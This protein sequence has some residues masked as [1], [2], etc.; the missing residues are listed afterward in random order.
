MKNI[1]FDERIGASKTINKAKVIRRVILF[2]IGF[3]TSIFFL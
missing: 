1:S 3:S 2:L